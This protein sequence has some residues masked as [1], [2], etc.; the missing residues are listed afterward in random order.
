[1]E[2]LLSL[3]GCQLNGGIK[4]YVVLLIA[5]VS[6]PHV[7][8]HIQYILSSFPVCIGIRT[9]ILFC[10]ILRFYPDLNKI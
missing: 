8:L 10:S 7:S 9:T 6:Q 2:F 3:V 1:M 4:K 5:A